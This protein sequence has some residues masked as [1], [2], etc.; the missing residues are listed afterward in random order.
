MVSTVRDITSDEFHLFGNIV[1]RLQSPGSDTDLRALV[2]EDI[3]RLLRA[4][5]GASFLWNEKTRRFEKCVRF[6]VDP[7]NLKRYDEWFQFRDPITAPL[8]ARRRATHVE[9]VISREELVKTEFYNDFLARDGLHHGVNMY[10]F[11]GNHDL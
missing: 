10:V 1:G 9:D 8:R 3:V 5:F 4:D 7:T 6:N 11:E 2:L